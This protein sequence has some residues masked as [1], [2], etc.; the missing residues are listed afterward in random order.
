MKP[1]ILITNDDGILSPGLLAL[2]EAVSDLGDLLV[3]APLF[4]QTGMGRSF[5]QGEDIGIIE[6]KMLLINDLSTLVYGVYGSPAQ[7][8]GRLEGPSAGR[9]SGLT[10]ITCCR[11]GERPFTSRRPFPE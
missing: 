6:E 2:S 7:A 4:Q 1:L 9:R 8:V 5:P 11:F 10:E 3:A